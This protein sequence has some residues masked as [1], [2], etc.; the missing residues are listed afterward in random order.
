MAE[1]RTK[2]DKAIV[3]W[4]HAAGSILATDKGMTGFDSAGKRFSR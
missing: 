3:K 1:E 2:H 4:W